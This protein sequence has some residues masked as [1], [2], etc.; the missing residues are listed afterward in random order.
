MKK[1]KETKKEKRQ[2]NVKDDMFKMTIVDTT[3]TR[4]SKNK[5][6][7]TITFKPSN[8]PQFQ[9]ADLD[10]LAMKLMKGHPEISYTDFPLPCCM[11]VH[12]D[13]T[14]HND[15]KFVLKTGE[16]IA[17]TKARLHL[18]NFMHEVVSEYARMVKE[19]Y[20]SVLLWQEEYLIRVRNNDEHFADLCNYHVIPK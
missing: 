13:A 12:A 4:K 8:T 16:H 20:M 19:T 3:F 18:N 14:C 2:K 11:V 6:R 9:A 17:E 10:G 5:I 15:D 1:N 7:C